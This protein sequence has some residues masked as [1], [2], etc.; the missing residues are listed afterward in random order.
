MKALFP[1]A[2]ENGIAGSSV[3]SLLATRRWLLVL[4]LSEA[5]LFAALVGAAQWRSLAS[6][7]R[8]ALLGSAVCVV[9]G[10]SLS[11]RTIGLWL[12]M[13][14]P[15]LL[16]LATFANGGTPSEVKWIAVSTSAGHVAYALVM[17]TGP[18]VGLVSVV[19]CTAALVL[20]WSMRPGNVVPGA[21]VVA[22]GWVTYASLAVSALA[23][24]FA[25]QVL[26]RR[27]KSEDDSRARLAARIQA[28]QEVQERS[29]M[30]R[31]AAVSVHERLLSTLRYLLQTPEPDREGLRTLIAEAG[32]VELGSTP[33]DLERSLRI[34]TAARVA[35]GIVKLDPSIIDLPVSDEARAAGRAAIVECAL[36]AVLHGGATAVVVAGEIDHGI[37]RIRIT[38]NGSGIPGDATPGLG[39]TSVL[40]S[41][42][43]AVGGSWTVSSQPGC[44]VVALAVPAATTPTTA[45]ILDDSF[46]QGR[47]LLSVPLL[48]VGGVGIAYD[49]LSMGTTLIGLV[50]VAITIAAVLIGARFIQQGKRPDVRLSSVALLALAITPWL[51]TYGLPQGI[52]V[53]QLAPGMVTAGYAIIAIALWGRRWQF[54]SAL[55][56]WATGMMALAADTAASERQPLVIGIVNCLVIVPVVVIVVSAATRRFR[57][58][59]DALILQR[60]AMNTEIVRA[61]AASVIDN[62]LSACV[63]QA[64]AII[65]RITDGAE[66]DAETRHELACLEGLIRATIQVD[67]VSSGEFARVAARLC[68]SAFSHSIP[69]QVGT[70]ISS[71]ETSPLPA[72]LVKGLESAIAT[73]DSITVRAMTAAD[74]DHL[75][76]YLHGP[77][78]DVQAI[79]SISKVT[80]QG[81]DVDMESEP[82]A[83]VLVLI[84]RSH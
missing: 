40:D 38:D 66:V 7:D 70:L 5:W 32:A 67:P 44:T 84:G 53:Q 50:V 22:D 77:S 52:S 56:I 14:A 27:A 18:A 75:S 82:G 60:A 65:A 16:L 35:A 2:N 20:S 26:L 10:W 24:W 68:N 12:V 55:A 47:T 78:V 81:V 71:P 49:A 69:S 46:A 11:R 42:L 30:W 43:S 1:N 31:A 41:G 29:R 37:V 4:L 45:T 79:A 28:E 51:A 59:Q 19:G 83:G 39:W 64:E 9:V 15:L 33:A 48:A 8:L 62:Q 36:N 74:E 54:V 76:V 57:R 17:L 25:W 21:L 63:A 58:A 6:S 61:N 73:A 3:A 13:G 72:D 80:L 23:L 34:A